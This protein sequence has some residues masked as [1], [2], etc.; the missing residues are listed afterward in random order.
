MR[1]SIF[2]LTMLAVASVQARADT[3]KAFYSGNELLKACEDHN[4]ICPGYIAGVV[5]GARA[6]A[7]WEKL[8]NPG[9]CTPDNGVTL[10]Q[11]RR[12]AE[13]YMRANPQNL[14]LTASSLVLNAITEAFPCP[15]SP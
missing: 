11:L 1:A 10:G 2:A 6:I 9:F 4:L 12:I 3:D 8:G 5:D 7:H 13:N 14:H 15:A